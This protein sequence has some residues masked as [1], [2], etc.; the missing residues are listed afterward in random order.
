M[1]SLVCRPGRGVFL[2]GL[3]LL[4]VGSQARAQSPA[5]PAP[6]DP[7]Q[8]QLQVDGGGFR[9]PQ[10][11]MQLEAR[12]NATSATYAVPRSVPRRRPGI[13]PAPVMAVPF[14]RGRIIARPA[15]AEDLGQAWEM[16]TPV[17]A[18]ISGPP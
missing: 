2:L 3:L 5:P 10:S 9:Q 7:S 4:A 17:M 18:S 14:P 12:T 8:P 13:T 6:G 11:N 15:G 16:P 1:F